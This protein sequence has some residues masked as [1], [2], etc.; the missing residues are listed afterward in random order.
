M[1]D[2]QYLSNPGPTGGKKGKK[3][4]K[5]NLGGKKTKDPG[6]DKCLPGIDKAEEN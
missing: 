2:M 3:E 5:E 6:T 4:K 1:Q